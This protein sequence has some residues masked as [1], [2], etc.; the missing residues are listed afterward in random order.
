M[1]ARASEA[2]QGATVGIMSA[3]A[4]DLSATDATLSRITRGLYVAVSGDVVVQF[5]GDNASVTL[6]GLAGGCWHAMQ[7]QKIIKTGTTATGLV[8]GY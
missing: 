1:A 2:L 4:V 8:A 5:A 6:T 7:L 3:S